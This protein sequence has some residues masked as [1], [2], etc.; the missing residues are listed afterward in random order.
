VPNYNYPSSIDWTVWWSWNRA[1][2]FATDR[3]YDYVHV[4][5]GYWGMYRVARNYPSL[6]SIHDWQWYINQAVMTVNA[7]TRGGVGFV[8]DGLM[9]ETVTRF[10]LDDLKRDGLT[11]NATLVESRMRSRWTVWSGERY[12]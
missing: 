4:I 3:A 6:V 7:M 8:N 10:L 12:P 11:N 2:S 9:G 1:A 5:A